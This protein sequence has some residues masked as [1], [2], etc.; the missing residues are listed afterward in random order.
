M[1]WFNILVRVAIAVALQFI[2]LLLAPKDER[3]APVADAERPRPNATEG[4][5]VPIVGGT[6]VLPIIIVQYGGETNEEIYS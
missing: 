4:Q 2:S 5:S 1:P 6:A 3:E